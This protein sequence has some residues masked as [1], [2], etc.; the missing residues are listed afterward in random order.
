[1]AR[2]LLLTEQCDRSYGV[3]F[4]SKLA[5]PP[6]ASVTH[7]RCQACPWR[8]SLSRKIALWHK[9]EQHKS[10]FVRKHKTDL[11]TKIQSKFSKLLVGRFR[12]MWYILCTLVQFYAIAI[13]VMDGLFPGRDGVEVMEVAVELARKVIPHNFNPRAPSAAKARSWLFSLSSG[14]KGW[15]NTFGERVTLN[16][17][18][19]FIEAH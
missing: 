9:I 8:K 12:G 7:H 19:W 1:M 5:G 11:F 14:L 18:E 4:A 15:H 10:S 17:L 3:A 16:L 2:L 6:I 13:F